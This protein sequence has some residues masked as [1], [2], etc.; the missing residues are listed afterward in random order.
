MSNRRDYDTSYGLEKE[1]SKSIERVANNITKNHRLRKEI[2]KLRR[3]RRQIEKVPDEVR[4][5]FE[6][7]GEEL[8]E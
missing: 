2:I 4:E 6:E 1:L 8:D 7:T 5:W 3:S